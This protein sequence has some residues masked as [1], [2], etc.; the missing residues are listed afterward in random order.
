MT[1]GWSDFV[2]KYIKYGGVYTMRENPE[3]KVPKYTFS[4]K[5]INDNQVQLTIYKKDDAQHDDLT[6]EILSSA[7]TTGDDIVVEKRDEDAENQIT[8]TVNNG[9]KTRLIIRVYGEDSWEV[10]SKFV[11]MNY[12]IY[13]TDGIYVIPNANITNPNGDQGSIGNP[14]VSIEDAI[15]SANSSN[16]KKIY[17]RGGVYEDINIEL[18]NIN[19]TA[20]NPIIITKLPGEHVKLKANK[21]TVFNIKS[22]SS[23]IVIDGLELDG[24]ANKE[25]YSVLANY[26]WDTQGDKH[27]GGGMGVHIDGHHIT[28]KNSII[29]DF[30]QKGINIFAGRYVNIHNN[31]VYNIGHTSLSGG[32]GIMRKWAKNFNSADSYDDTYKYR[33]DIYGNLIFNV[34]QRIYS[35]VFKKGYANL[36]IDEG[37]SILFDETSDTNQ[38]SRIAQNLV[39]YGGTDHIRLKHNP[40][41]EVL[42]NSVLSDFNRANPTPD[43]ITIKNEMPNLTMKYN[44]VATASNSFTFDLNKAGDSVTIEDNYGAGGNIKGSGTQKIGDNPSDIFANPQ[45][46]DFSSVVKDAN[47]NL[48]NN[49]GVSSD[50]LSKM[51]Q[52]ASEYGIEIKSSGWSHDHVQ[53]TQTIIKNIPAKYFDRSNYYIG[54][55]NIEE[56]RKALYIKFIDSDGKWLY[57]KIEIDGKNWSDIATQELTDSKAFDLKNIKIRKTKNGKNLKGAYVYQ[58]IL[59]QEWVDQYGNNTKITNSD[60]TVSNL[61]QLDESN[62]EHKNILD[63]AAGKKL[64]Q[65]GNSN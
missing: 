2:Y 59:P 37:K 21:G 36:T 3:A 30:Y 34:E 51:L 53:N 56:G 44:L 27:L 29:H 10:M 35:R 13:P 20:D 9:L 12:G 11:L 42:N 22:N 48:I 60:G 40:N 64:E 18:D 45:A 31:I 63:Y 8:V 4:T 33:Y 65:S 32:H 15:N 50:I 54:E 47:G 58:L 61:V 19:G 46:N 17:I 52:M 5:R 39:L 23:H 26:W 55:S 41:M 24:G 62:S 6:I 7:Y 49:L 1:T 57:D 43:G 14:F 16:K 38:K 28:V 25:H